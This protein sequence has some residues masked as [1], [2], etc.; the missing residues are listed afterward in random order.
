M[1]IDSS[2]SIVEPFVSVVTP[3]YNT[4]SYLAQC[5]ESV[6]SQVYQNWE[7][8]LVNNLSTDKSLDVAQ[9]YAEK[10][11][12]I[13][14]VTNDT[15][16]GQVQ[17]YNGALGHISPDSKYCKIVQ[18][19]DWIFP[20]CLMEMVKVAEGNPSVGIIGAYRLDDVRVNCDGLPYPSFFVPGRDICRKNL[21]KMIFVFGSPTS[22]MFLSDIVRSRK[23]FFS[24]TSHHEDSDACFEILQKYDYGFVHK[25]LT[26]TRRENESISTR[27]RLYD[28]YYLQCHLSSVLRY[29]HYYLDSTEY[30][31]CLN[32][33]ENKYYRF[34]GEFFWSTNR[35]ELLKYHQEGLSNINHKLSYAK[36]YKFAF[37]AIVDFVL[38]IKR[39]VKRLLKLISIK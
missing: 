37:L 24:E 16:V 13:R 23:P 11:S 34:L 2:T 28:P 17:N 33:I 6:L 15:F 14:V 1:V 32:A 27:I 5:I 29:G 38:D 30:K 4:E 10:D 12:R 3:F 9:F 25:V 36:V 35:K 22:L 20:E 8:I 18:A 39:F 26:F 21:L 31:I 7:Y 19:D